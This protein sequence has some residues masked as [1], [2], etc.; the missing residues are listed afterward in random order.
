MLRTSDTCRGLEEP[1]LACAERA[2]LS[3]DGGEAPVAVSAS[4]AVSLSARGDSDWDHL[5]LRLRWLRKNVINNKY[6]IWAYYFLFL[7]ICGLWL[8][9]SI[10]HSD[11]VEE[12]TRYSVYYVFQTTF[13]LLLVPMS[14]HF[15][16]E[17]LSLNSSDGSAM[18]M[19]R[20]S[21]AEWASS[22]E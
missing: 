19:T 18:P 2:A 21:A 11:F 9:N 10:Y 13:T 5:P 12:N 8:D 1:I 22:R 17:A 20:I 15:L 14:I 6:A 16:K 7:G 4:L 3:A